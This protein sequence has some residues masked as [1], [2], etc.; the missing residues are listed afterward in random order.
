VNCLESRDLLAEYAVGAL[1][2]IER[3]RIER[4]MESCPG[5]A[6][7]AGELVAAASAAAFELPPVAPGAALEERVVQRVVA[8]SHRGKVRKRRAARALWVAAACAALLA[9][10]A[11]GGAVAMRGQVADL[12][13]QVSTTRVSLSELK[14]LIHSL[15]ASGHVSQVQMVPIDRRISGGGTG[16]I[17]SSQQALDWMFMQT[18]IGHPSAGPYRVVLATRGGRTID[19][20]TLTPLGKDQYVMADEGGPREFTQS[21]SQVAVVIVLA[22]DGHPVLRGVV[23]PSAGS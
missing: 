17:F 7:E 15:S 21:L 9:A 11:L 3:R 8:E 20:G 5:C 22:P 14:Q 16:I 2:P 12:K 19:G 13:Q 6:K 10:G 23:R 4:H 1:S 18:T